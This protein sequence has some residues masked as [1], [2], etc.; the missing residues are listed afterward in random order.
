[1]SI[2]QYYY[3]VSSSIEDL[4]YDNS[5]LCLLVKANQNT[6]EMSFLFKIGTVIDMLSYSIETF[7]TVAPNNTQ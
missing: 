1:M 5:I 4:F 2:G 7:P 6:Y 3:I